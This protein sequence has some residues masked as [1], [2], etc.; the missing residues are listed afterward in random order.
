MTC[1]GGTRELLGSY[2]GT[3]RELLGNCSGA[4]RELIGSYS[5][6]ARELL[7][8]CSSVTRDLLGRFTGGGLQNLASRARPIQGLKGPVHHYLV[9]GS[10]WGTCSFAYY[11]RN[12]LIGHLN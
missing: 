12:Y 6:T 4:T 5:G 1:S 7:G 3:A 9:H 8:N 11:G 10:Y 2:S